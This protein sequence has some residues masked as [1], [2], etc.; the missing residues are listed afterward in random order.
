MTLQEDMDSKRD[1]T[2]GEI[3]ALKSKYRRTHFDH[4]PGVDTSHF[5]VWVMKGDKLVRTT[6]RQAQAKGYKIVAGTRNRP[7]IEVKHG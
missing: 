3:D 4:F 6:K 5:K 7:E 2:Q 1:W